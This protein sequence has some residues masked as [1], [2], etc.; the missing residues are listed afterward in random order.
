MANK[1][2]LNPTAIEN[3][4]SGRICDPATLGSRIEVLPS[5]KKRWKFRRRLPGGK[6][7]LKLRL[8]FFPTFSI[9]EARAW[10][11]N[12]IITEAAPPVN[13][14]KGQLVRKFCQRCGR[15]L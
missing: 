4:V 13:F 2:A 1:V 5:G 14:R 8:G 9:A 10:A 15:T 3:L 7:A 6:P 12:P 11:R